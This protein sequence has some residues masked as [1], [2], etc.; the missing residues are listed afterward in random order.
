MRFW[1]ISYWGL[2]GLRQ[3]DSSKRNVANGWV[4]RCLELGS[5]GRSAGGV[6]LRTAAAAIVAGAVAAA[7]VA[8]HKRGFPANVSRLDALPTVPLPRH[9]AP[10]RIVR[11][12]AASSAAAAQAAMGAPPGGVAARAH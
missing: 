1:Q 3:V 10:V 9:G 5:G 2:P 12:R 7:A 4:G 11:A 8:A 6:R